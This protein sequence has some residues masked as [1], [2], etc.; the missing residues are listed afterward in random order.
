MMILYFIIFIISCVLLFKSGTWT[1]KSLSKITAFLGLSEFFAAFVLVAVATSLPEFFVGLTSAL[2]RRPS[3]SLGN[4]LGANI[5]NLT[6]VIFAAL[7]VVK[8]ITFKKELV[9]HDLLV[10]ALVGGPSLILMVD[11]Q[12]SRREGIILL[13]IYLAFLVLQIMFA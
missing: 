9:R 5:I 10:T 7:M 6:L 4:V 12:L 1:V 13:L 3:L 8:K 11:G 2:A